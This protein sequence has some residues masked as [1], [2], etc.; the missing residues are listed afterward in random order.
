PGYWPP[1]PTGRFEDVPM[2]HWAAGWI[3]QLVNDGI[4][5]GCDETHFCPDQLVSRAEIASMLGKAKYWPMPFEPSEASGDQFL[6]VGS[7]FW[8]ADWIEELASIGV[9][10]GCKV[11]RYCPEEAV[12]RAELAVFLVKTFNIPLQNVESF[13]SE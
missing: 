2:G 3:E 10:E 9:V 6:D 13:T 5:E 8:A 7:E 4:S 1:T 11:G 12:S